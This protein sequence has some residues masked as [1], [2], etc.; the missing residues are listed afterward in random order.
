MILVEFYSPKDL[1]IYPNPIRRNE[2]LTIQF[3]GFK[4]EILIVVVDIYGNELYSKI[5]IEHQNGFV[6]ACDCMNRLISG[7]YII[8]ATSMN[9]IYKKKLRELGLER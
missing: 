5:I 4:E 9:E 7:T 2:E 3:D 8:I 6:V 1:K